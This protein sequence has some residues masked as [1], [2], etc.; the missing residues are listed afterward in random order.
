MKGAKH[1]IRKLTGLKSIE[2]YSQNQRME[3]WTP[4]AE[5]SEKHLSNCKVL[6]NRHALIDLLPTNAV[7][8]EIGVGTGDFS[9]YILEKCRPM[10][11]HLYEVDSNRCLDAEDR[12]SSEIG[13]G[14]VH[15]HEG[16]SW[17]EMEKTED[18]F[19]WIYIDGNHTYEG[20]KNDLEASIE[21]IKP[22][23]IM[24]MNDYVFFAPSDFSKY[25]VMEATHEFCLENN[26]EFIYLALQGRGYF[27]VAIRKIQ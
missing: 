26:F 25:G 18:L 14:I 12:F 10:R 3:M 13:S 9:A 8:A 24:V 4:A 2:D 27:D 5:L 22:D 1:K 20:C 11:L 7:C 23:G 19:D 6:P 21:K 16:Q 17:V 15:I